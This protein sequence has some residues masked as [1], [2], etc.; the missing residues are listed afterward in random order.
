MDGSI[1]TTDDFLKGVKTIGLSPLSPPLSRLLVSLPS[2]SLVSL[3]VLS[4]RDVIAT[5]LGPLGGE[6]M[7]TI[8]R[9]SG[10]R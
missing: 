10:K 7:G 6:H 4:S 1:K 5:P 3:R 9:R 2:L 8:L